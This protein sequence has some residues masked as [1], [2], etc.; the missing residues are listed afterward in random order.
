ME[1]T[2]SLCDLE[3]QKTGTLMRKYAFPCIVSLLVGALYNI[4]DQLFIANAD[5]LGSNGNAANSV[6]FPL[7]VAVLSIATM[8]GDGC[9]A[10]MSISLGKKDGRTAAK[11]AGNAITLLTLSGIVLGAVYLIFADGILTLFG[12]NV[13]AETAA[14]SKEYFFWI[15]LGIPFYMFG[16]GLNPVIR[17]DGSPKYAMM[18]LTVGAVTNCILDP[19]FIFPL[20]MGMAGAAIATIV[21]QIASAVFA[22]VYLFKI[23]TVKLTKNCFVPSGKVC[24]NIF[25][26]GLTSFLS[27][28]SIVCTMAAVLNMC[29]KYGAVD[30][31]FGLSEYAQIPTAV[32]GIVM[33]FF[34]IVIAIAIGLSAGCIPIVGYNIGAERHDRVREIMRKLLI[35]ELLVGLVATVICELFP[36]K[37]I[38]I[39]GA[40]NESEHYTKFAVRCIRLFMM[41]TPLACFNK[42]TFI[43]LQSLG[44]AKEST[45]LSLLREIVF[46]VGLVLILPLFWGLEGILWFMAIADALTFVASV[47]VIAITDKKLTMNER[48]VS[49]SE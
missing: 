29:R 44:K 34:Q 47:S 28:I 30:P 25:S 36:S 23:K 6:V 45:L 22:F 17:S 16:Q 4:V 3:T 37:L 49:P 12:A 32:I 26:L 7:T 13:N 35:A 18:S 19:I 1:K 2:K 41:M 33:K 38:G 40:A 11:S 8:I 20:K 14:F 31:V 9:C 21:G 42:G 27:Q 24:K 15:S 46:G 48:N 39:F 5:Y 10:F 43:F